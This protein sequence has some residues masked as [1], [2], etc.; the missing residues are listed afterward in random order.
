MVYH[1][2]ALPKELAPFHLHLACASSVAKP[3]RA[4]GNVCSIES[5]DIYIDIVTFDI[6]TIFGFIVAVVLFHMIACRHSCYPF[7]SLVRSYC[8]FGPF[9]IVGHCAPTIN[10]G[11]MA[12]NVPTINTIAKNIALVVFF[13]IILVN[14]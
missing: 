6:T 12:A 10:D 1:H 13:N 8:P 4:V 2:H 11:D 5:I 7:H 3:L 14:V 9:H